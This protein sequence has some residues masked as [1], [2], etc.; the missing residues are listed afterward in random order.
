VIQPTPVGDV[1][2][3]KATYDSVVG[4]IAV[5]WEKQAAGGMRITTTIPANQAAT[6]VFPVTD[7]SSIKEA[8]KPVARAPGVRGVNSDGK[9]NVSVVVES[10]DFVFDLVLS[11]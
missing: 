5:R 7:P 3:T 11:D 4:T 10:G 2:W 8:G 6:I 1:T 9:Q